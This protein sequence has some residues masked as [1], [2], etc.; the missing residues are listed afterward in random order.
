MIS[1]IA[2]SKMPRNT[3]GLALFVGIIT[4]ICDAVILQLN[5]FEIRCVPY[6]QPS[7]WI[8]VPAVWAIFCAAVAVVF[9]PRVIRRFTVV[10][11]VLAGPGL[12]LLSRL[13]SV[14]KKRAGF[15]VA[16]SSFVCI[17]AAALLALLAARVSRNL[18]LKL[19]SRVGWIAALVALSLLLAATPIVRT[20]RRTF[21]P[22]FSGIMRP[23]VLLIFL[24]TVRWDDAK[25]MP[26]LAKFAATSLSFEDA[27][28][29]APW[30]LPSHFAV[31]TGIDPWSVDFDEETQSFQDQDPPLAKIFSARGY[32]SAA[33]FA[34][35]L[36]TPGTGLT[37]GFQEFDY[38]RS[39]A[40]CRSGLAWLLDHAY[41]Y[42]GR[43]SPVCSVYGGSKVTG[44]ALHFVRNAQRPYFLTLNF[45]DAHAPYLVEPYCRDKS[46]H[47]YTMADWTLF[48]SMTAQG[49]QLP[50]QLV[51]TIHNQYRSAL[52]C[53]DRS[54]GELFSELRQQSDYDHTIVVIVG[55]HGEQFGEHGLYFHGNSLYAP[56]LRVPLVLKPADRITPQ[57][58]TNPV[59]ITDI[60]WTL[61]QL[62]GLARNSRGLFTANRHV[63][64]ASF[65]TVAGR[66]ARSSSAYSGVESNY[67]LI[68]LEDGR[69][70]IYD[71]S[72]DP[73]EKQA[74]TSTNGVPAIDDL[75]A[76][77]LRLFA[78]EQRRRAAIFSLDYLR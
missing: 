77:S 62:T 37:R 63:V 20:E 10:A 56:V 68:R 45:M 5:P 66:G 21:S 70:E 16:T 73:A 27:W 29:P 33:I 1:A 25:A 15:S 46:F 4:G 22:K 74:L 69:E 3:I 75:R 65:E 48:T 14:L 57:R 61:L 17:A 72:S 24:D 28:S 12:L 6:L 31:F 18:E 60:Y 71:Y 78:N 51:S 35:P 59:S 2:S 23:N 50:P 11:V 67:H 40:G 54:L 42:A 9:L 43:R 36:L 34:N 39:F 8:F 76:S 58:V 55:D 64:A 32:T 13:G 19:H 53:L 44:E 41:T 47:S 30:T 49:S 26:N 7:V 38:S 52:G